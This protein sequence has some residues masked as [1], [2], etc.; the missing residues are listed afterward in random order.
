MNNKLF[1]TEGTETSNTFG[2]VAIGAIF[3]SAAI[4]TKVSQLVVN[5][6]KLIQL[7]IKPFELPF[8]ISIK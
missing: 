8:Q 1:F 2:E 4:A 3:S 7:L 6:F 5:N